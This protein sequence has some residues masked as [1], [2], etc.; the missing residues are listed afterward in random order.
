MKGSTHNLKYLVDE[1]HCASIASHPIPSKSFP[2]KLAQPI[3]G[4]IHFMCQLMT[5]LNTYI[6]NLSGQRVDMAS[7]GENN[8]PHYPFALKTACQ[9]RPRA[10]MEGDC[11]GD[12]CNNEVN[13]QPEFQRQ[14]FS[15]SSQSTYLERG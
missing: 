3:R 13:L 10:G 1:R 5:R 6:S 11:S 2:D 15:L 12:K 14:K 4:E 9:L 8:P 7:T